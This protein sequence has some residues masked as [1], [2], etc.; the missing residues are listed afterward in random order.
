MLKKETTR[1]YREE[2]QEP[3]RGVRVDL[4]VRPGRHRRKRNLDLKGGGEVFSLSLYDG[5]LDTYLPTYLP[6]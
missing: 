2:G 3:R 1:H 5:F 4:R 6:T